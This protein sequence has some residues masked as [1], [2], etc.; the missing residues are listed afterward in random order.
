MGAIIMASLFSP[1]LFKGFRTPPTLAESRVISHPSRSPVGMRVFVL[2]VCCAFAG[3]FQPV[4]STGVLRSAITATDVSPL[5]LVRRRDTRELHT[6]TNA[7]LCDAS[8]LH[9]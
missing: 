8:L 9:A 1:Q 6:G 2:V 3:A 5:M 7:S 4:M